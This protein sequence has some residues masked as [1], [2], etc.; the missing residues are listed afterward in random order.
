MHQD[1]R[2]GHSVGNYSGDEKYAFEKLGDG[3]FVYDEGPAV[4]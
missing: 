4:E 3:W 2:A 1:G